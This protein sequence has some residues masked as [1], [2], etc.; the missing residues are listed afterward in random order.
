MRAIRMQETGGPEVLRVEE[1][2]DPQPGPTEILVEVSAAGV[3]F[4]DTY[5]R[6]G[7]YPLDLP[8]T[9]GLEGAGTVRAV[10]EGVAKELIGR[11][12]AWAQAKGS[13]AELVAL[14]AE[15]AVPVP[16]EVDDHS[17]AAAMLQGMTAHYLSHSTYEL[18]PDDTA[19]VY[20]AA[21]GVGRLLVQLAKLRGAR[22]LACTSTAE[23]ESVVRWLGADEV[24]RYR[25]VSVPDRV[26]D[27]TD[28]RGVDVV[29]DSVGR[30]TFDDS[31]VCLRPRG[32]MVLYGQS[33]GPVPPLDLQRLNRR[34][35][36][37]A[38]RP[39]LGHYVATR[40]ELERRAIE[41]LGLIADGRLELHIHE[42]YPLDEAAR[43]HADLG[44]GTTV[45]K[46]LLVP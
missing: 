37:Y 11:R 33:S 4:I 10:G 22:V 25:D 24:I 7:A 26:R 23:K 3:N 38:T 35:S 9:P 1:A 16:D 41:V 45:G 27:L 21:G 18:G 31:L 13:Y 6:S 20:A 17:A 42:R 5:H 44:S 19:L 8:A 12:V 36:L 28:G 14:P 46:L 43:A 29:Y 39:S 34:G 32:F 30:D 40:E 2:P 15:R